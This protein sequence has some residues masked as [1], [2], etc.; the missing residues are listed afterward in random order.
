MRKSCQ[1]LK[2]ASKS[3]PAENEKRSF[4]IST[5]EESKLFINVN[6]YNFAHHQKLNLSGLIGRALSAS[7]IPNEG[8]Q[9]EEVVN[10]L[11]MLYHKRADSKG[12]VYLVY[13]T[14]LY[15]AEPSQ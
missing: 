3:H 15:L 10:N 5:V 6:Y 4:L 12:F 1:I 11:Q 2:Q 14:D 7:Y 8:E 13:R 9:Y